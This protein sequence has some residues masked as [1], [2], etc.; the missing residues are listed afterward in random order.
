M[1]LPTLR[2]AWDGSTAKWL[3][4]TS[5]A[6]A[7]GQRRAYSIL[8]RIDARHLHYR[9]AESR[10]DNTLTMVGGVFDGDGKYVAG[11][12]TRRWMLCLR[13]ASR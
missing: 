5:A 8:A 6:K 10:N 3:A 2:V 4:P 1:G 9:K 13:E 11:T 12:A 7:L